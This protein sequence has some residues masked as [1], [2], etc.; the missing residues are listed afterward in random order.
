M[1]DTQHAQTIAIR[2]CTHAHTG[3]ERN[4]ERIAT[5]AERP[6][7]RVGPGWGGV[8]EREVIIAL[9]L[10]NLWPVMEEPGARLLAELLQQ[11]AASTFTSTSL[12][13]A[14]ASASGHNSGVLVESISIANNALGP[15]GCAALARALPV[16]TK[17][18]VLDLR[19][20]CLG[21]DGATALAQVLA[22]CKSLEVLRLHNNQI[23]DRGAIALAQA[24][25]DNSNRAL[26]ELGLSGNLITDKGAD[27]LSRA[28]ELAV[29]VQSVEITGNPLGKI[30]YSS[31]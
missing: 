1:F 3:G 6:G 11:T 9:A 15:L 18:S 24:L 20:N 28:L 8:E 30:L 27:A 19:G 13:G 31:V 23:G 2:I 12:G 21:D 25:G 10:D 22:Q 14:S 16:C 7:T 17:L 29:S 5:Y 26:R 4:G